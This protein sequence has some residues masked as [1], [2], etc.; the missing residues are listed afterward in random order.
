MLGAEGK[1]LR[2]LIREHCDA[3]VSIPMRGQISS[4][5]VSVAAGVVLYE[6][7]RQSIDGKLSR[8]PKVAGGNAQY[9][10]QAMGKVFEAAGSLATSFARQR[11]LIAAVERT[12]SAIGQEKVSNHSGLQAILNVF[13]V[14]PQS[15][16]PHHYDLFL[17]AARAER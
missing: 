8:L 17:A 11:H 3:L 1:G 15:L 10:D 7:L 13:D 6:T 16:I 4:L 12:I 9:M 5:N 14:D 2:R